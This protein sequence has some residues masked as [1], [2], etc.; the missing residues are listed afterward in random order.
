MLQ[1][2]IDQRQAVVVVLSPA[3]AQSKY[4]KQE[5]RY[6]AAMGKLIIPALH[7]PTPRIPMD[8]HSLQWAD[9]LASYD[10]GLRHLL[11]SLSRFQAMNDLS[12]PLSGLSQ[13]EQALVPERVV[14]AV[15]D[16]LDAP[17]DTSPAVTRLAAI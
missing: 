8:L 3:A 13:H 9:F 6:A 4:V 7:L 1:D 15:L 10:N 5:Y 2:A 17:V 11:H 12:R 16:A 14:E